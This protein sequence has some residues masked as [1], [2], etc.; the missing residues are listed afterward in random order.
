MPALIKD[1]TGPG[2]I[3]SVPARASQMRPLFISG[4]EPYMQRIRD[5][6]KSVFQA[7]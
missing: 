7:T 5:L 4:H 2:Q 1:T 3:Q 6:V